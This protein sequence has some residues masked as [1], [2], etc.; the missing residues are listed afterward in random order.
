MVYVDELTRPTAYCLC[1][2]FSVSLYISII[3]IFS[4]FFVLFLALF[5]FIFVHRNLFLVSW[6]SLDFRRKYAYAVI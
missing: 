3:F 5:R 1:F 2:P 4:T 6:R